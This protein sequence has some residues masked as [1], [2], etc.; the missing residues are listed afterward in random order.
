[1]E[2]NAPRE[3]T[4]LIERAVLWLREH[5]PANWN[6]EQSNRPIAGVDQATPQQVDALIDIR[7]PSGLATLAVEAKPSF[8]PRDVEA[9]LPQLTRVIRSLANNPPVLV[10]APWLSGRTQELL[11]REEVNF[12]DLSGNALIR[13]EYPAVYIRTTGATRNPNP[14]PRP[15]ARVR[16]PKAAR[17]VRLLA[18]VRPPYGVREIAKAAGLAPGYV[19]RLLDA[20]DRE[21][22]IDR[23][24]KG[25]VES[26][27]VPDLLRRWAESYDVLKSNEGQSFVAPAGAAVALERLAAVSVQ[28]RVAITGSFAAIRL[29]PVA[30][31][32][33]LLAYAEN[34]EAIVEALD[35]LPAD[36]GAN[37][38]LLRPFDRVVWERT[39]T[40][41][42]LEYVAPPQAAVD[43]L[44]GTGR[45]PSE[46]EALLTWMIEH[47]SAWRLNSLSELLAGRER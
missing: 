19:S 46:G 42:G 34:L 16:G 9:L 32:A 24:R 11:E 13:I 30:A 12:L 1:M 40:Q 43:S 38:V 25:E 21:A 29:A 14:E 27:E 44:T 2:A 23:S 22:L 15:Q 20:L 31:P 18:D 35:L 41:R 45:M 5:L 47:E 6:V 26:V 36:E 3:G 37:V 10:V 39:T 8:A 4:R 17:L 7:S 33:L 28:S